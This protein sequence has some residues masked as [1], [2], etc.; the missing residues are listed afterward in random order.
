MGAPKLPD[1]S[2]G[3]YM[4]QKHAILYYSARLSAILMGTDA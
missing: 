2:F 1:S 3:L 4:F